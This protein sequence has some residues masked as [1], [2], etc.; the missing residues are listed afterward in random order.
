MVLQVLSCITTYL[1]LLLQ[2]G[3]TNLELNHR[4]IYDES[5]QKWEQSF[6]EKKDDVGKELKKL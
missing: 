5:L 6:M 4:G 1:V 2:V 3:K